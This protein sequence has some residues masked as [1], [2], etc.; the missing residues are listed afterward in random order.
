[1][2]KIA[3]IDFGSQYTKLIARRIRELE[4]Y[5]EILPHDIPPESISKEDVWGIILSGGPESVFK[6]G[7]KLNENIL[8]KGIPILGI[9]YGHQII[10][11]LMGGRVSSGEKGEYGRRRFYVIKRSPL[12]QGLP[13]S[14]D[15]WMSHSDEVISLPQGFIIT[16]RTEETKIGSYENRERNIYG[17]Q[18]HPEVSHTHYGME[19]LK[20]FVF[21]IC[22]AE[23]NWNLEK[24]LEKKIK[25]IKDEVKEKTVISALSGGIDSTVAT[26]MVGKAVG[27]RLNA[28]FVNTGLVRTR[29]VEYVKNFFASKFN[30]KMVDASKEF[31]QNLK[32]ITDPEHKRKI[33]GRLFIETFTK[34][35][36]EIDAEYLVQGTLYPDVIES[37]KTVSSAL[38]K[39]HHNVGGLPE[40]LGL[41]LIEPLRE[42]FKDEVRKLV[43]LLGLPDYF[44]YKHPFPGPG[45]GIRIVGEVTEEK[46]KI[47]DK[48]DRIVE[49]VIK[50]SGLYNKVWQSFPVLLPVRSVGVVGDARAYGYTVSIRIVESQDGMT[51]DWVKV[52]HNILDEISRRIT[53]EIKEINRVLYDIT[54]KPPATIEWE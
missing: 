40:N 20:N 43:P 49:D 47:I 9:C 35:A 44:R 13:E 30:F 17:V 29:D 11:E 21:K 37:G 2:K 28:I 46:I 22:K 52:D 54:S 53:G 32:G 38:I 31:L 3:I 51:A 23:K 12:F 27:E 34:A 24:F 7:P 36:R 39:S 25:E 18:F 10:A 1:M 48:A 4:V 26:Y 50:E 8:K 5:S 42:L 41:K 15:V 19:V 16:G 14:F 6:G 33:I 45:Y